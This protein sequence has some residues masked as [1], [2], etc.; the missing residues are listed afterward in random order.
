MKSNMYS[1]ENSCYNQKW[2]LLDAGNQRYYLI[3]KSDEKRNMDIEGPVGTEGANIQ[4]WTHQQGINQ[5][6]WYIE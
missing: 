3:P 5:F 2:K 6:Q 4:I 1:R